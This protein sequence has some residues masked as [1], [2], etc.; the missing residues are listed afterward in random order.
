M[1]V[2]EIKIILEIF[3][4]RFLNTMYIINSK[5]NHIFEEWQIVA[6]SIWSRIGITKLFAH[7]LEG[8]RT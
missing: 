6:C 5:T 3:N 4:V 1:I 2:Y 8:L 7:F